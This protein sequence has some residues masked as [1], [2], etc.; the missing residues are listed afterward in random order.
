MTHLLILSEL[1]FFA[2][3]FSHLALPLLLLAILLHLIDGFLAFKL[4]IRL[5]LSHFSLFSRPTSF[6]SSARDLHF[7]PFAMGVFFILLGSGLCL[8]KLGTFFEKA[9]PLFFL[10]GAAISALILTLQK[11]EKKA[12][13]NPLFLLQKEGLAVARNRFK[14]KEVRASFPK[15]P[16]EESHFLSPKYPLLRRTKFKGEKQFDLQLFPGE[17]PNVIFVILESFRAKNV[18]CLGAE[19]PLSPYFDALAKKGILFSQFHSIGNLTCRA[20]IASLFGIPPSHTSR[21]LGAYVDIPLF[22]I[23]RILDGAGYHSALI[24]GGPIAFNHGIEF[25][26]AQGFNTL[27]GK[28][29]IEKIKETLPGTSWG[30]YDEHLMQFAASWL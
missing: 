23:P 3:L 1:L 5:E 8:F 27:I 24:Q 19:I 13:L 10:S 22:G 2:S 18:G 12:F 16:Q 9:N 21:Q 11:K 7:F 15:F 14:K 25:F 30:I 28:R 6:L 20:S 29:D 17:K 4:N 26:E